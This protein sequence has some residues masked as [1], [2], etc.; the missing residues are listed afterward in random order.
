[1]NAVP[2]K[3][4]ERKRGMLVRS[5]GWT[6]TFTSLP[7][8]ALF[9]PNPGWFGIGC[10]SVLKT[11]HCGNHMDPP[12]LIP[13]NPNKSVLEDLGYHKV[14]GMVFKWFPFKARWM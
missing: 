7:F 10:G 3:D 2:V 5:G 4:A 12:V 13:E 8:L 11:C 14:M 9:S 6:S 1:M